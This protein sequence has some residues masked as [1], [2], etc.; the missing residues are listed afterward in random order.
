MATRLICA[1]RLV[2]FWGKIKQDTLAIHVWR[3]FPFLVDNEIWPKSFFS[4]N[5][6]AKRDP[7][8]IYIYIYIK[9]LAIWRCHCWN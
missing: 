7:E 5:F 3:Y 1:K 8:G 2:V 9:S 6:T 4:T